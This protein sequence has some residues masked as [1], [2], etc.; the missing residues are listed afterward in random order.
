[1]VLGILP[2]M[3]VLYNCLR[4]HSTLRATSAAN[5]H[6]HRQC[7]AHSAVSALRLPM[8]LVI[9]PLMRVLYRSLHSHSTLSH[10]S[11]QHSFTQD[12]ALLT[13]LSVR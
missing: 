7:A 5:T 4:S 12:S 11:N 6:S 2:L 10:V 9:L 3:R 8:V 13:V 1:M